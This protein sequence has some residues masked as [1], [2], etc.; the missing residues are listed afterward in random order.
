MPRRWLRTVK[1]AVL[2]AAILGGGGGMPLLD[3]V[4]YH[5]L[6]PAR[7]SQPHFEPSGAHCHAELCRLDFKAPYS[8]QAESLDLR[9]Q[10]M[11]TPFRELAFAPRAPR[12]ADPELLPHPRAPPGL[13]A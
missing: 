1:A 11:T 12:P 2:A 7:S 10:A 9:V 13:P 3:V 5:G 6:A 4:L 8:T